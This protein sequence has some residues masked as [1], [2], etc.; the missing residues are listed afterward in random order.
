[1]AF[2]YLPPPKGRRLFILGGGGGNSV[3]YADICMRVGLQVR[4]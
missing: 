4:E 2:L 1:M 3:Y